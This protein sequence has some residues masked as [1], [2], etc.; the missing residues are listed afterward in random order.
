MAN[1]Y[2]SDDLLDF[3]DHA[4]SRGLL[5]EATA[6]AFAVATRNVVGVLS[7]EEKKDLS[8]HDLDGIIK[9]FTNKRA[10]DFN[11]SS[12][13]EYGRRVRKAVDLYLRW[14]ADP[15]NF[16]VTTRSTSVKRKRDK[17]DEAVATT[18][19]MA[20]SVTADERPGSYHSAIPVRP[21]V[22]VTLLNVPNDLTTVEADRLAAFVKMLAVTSD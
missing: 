17:P 7:E 21:G 19:P 1:S 6:R 18:E 5:P 9:R 3:L 2:S 13:K 10:R 22:V 16:S 15:A 4:G 20:L 12:L 11:P 8:R 14:R